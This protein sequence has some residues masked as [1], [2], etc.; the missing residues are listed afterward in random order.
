M[1]PGTT[2]SLWQKNKDDYRTVTQRNVSDDLKTHENASSTPVLA[3]KSDRK[4]SKRERTSVARHF[5]PKHLSG[6]CPV[7][8]HRRNGV[9]GYKASSRQEAPGT[10]PSSAHRPR[11]TAIDRTRSRAPSACSLRITSTQHFNTKEVSGAL[12]RAERGHSPEKSGLNFWLSPSFQPGEGAPL[13]FMFHPPSN[14]RFTTASVLGGSTV[15]QTVRFCTANCPDL[16]FPTNK[17]PE[18]PPRI[19]EQPDDSSLWLELDKCIL[20][21]PGE[22]KQ[23]S[24]TEDLHLQGKTETSPKIAFVMYL[25]NNRTLL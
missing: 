15:Y 25:P 2:V 4:H 1:G 14:D 12:T 10:S 20:S 18:C 13:S 24:F 22:E 19:P 16:T 9:P 7:R 21:T 11:F 5:R 8:R 23:L 3:V 6:R 17:Q